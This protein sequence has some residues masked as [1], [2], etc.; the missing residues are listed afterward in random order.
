MINGIS[1]YE[2]SAETSYLAS[3][4]PF[5]EIEMEKS[6]SKELLLLGC[7]DGQA[8]NELAAR[9]ESWSFCGVDFN[10]DYIAKAKIG[11]PD[12]VVYLNASFAEITK[13]VGAYGMIASPGLLSWISEQDRA[14]VF[15]ILKECSKP[16]TL[17]LF[18]YD[19]EFFWGELKGVRETFLDL[20]MSIGDLEQARMITHGLVR[21][22]PVSSKRK[23]EHLERM[24]TEESAL[25]HW[26]FQPYWQ[27]FFPSEI[28]ARMSGAGFI[29]E[30]EQLNSMTH[31]LSP[32]PYLESLYRRVE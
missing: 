6:D 5:L 10:S 24:L 2:L 7:G 15:R 25:K 14:E 22:M 12:N 23:R 18:G 28:N 29:P 11:S 20:W 4:I 16:G 1:N 26:L 32:S 21:Q 3:Q 17:A 31:L 13:E 9:K 8:L 30:S 19:S 27:P